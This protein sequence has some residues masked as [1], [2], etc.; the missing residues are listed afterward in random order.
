MVSLQP[1]AKQ[2]QFQDAFL[3]KK[4]NKNDKKPCWIGV[5]GGVTTPEEK[6]RKA[7]PLTKMTLKMNLLDCLTKENISCIVLKYTSLE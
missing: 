3:E 6:V 4:S 1:K 7:R 2:K 5:V